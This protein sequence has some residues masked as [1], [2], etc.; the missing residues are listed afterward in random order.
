VALTKEVAVNYFRGKDQMRL[1]TDGDVAHPG[2]VI[3]D[4]NG[5]QIGISTNPLQINVGEVSDV[6]PQSFE[7]TS[8]VT[9]DSPADLDCNTELGR[10]A[11][12]GYIR[13][14]GAGDFTVKFSTDG[15]VFGDALTVKSDEVL[16]FSNISVDTI[17]I[18]WIA[19]SAYRVG[20]N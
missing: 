7:D 18:T 16:R 9:G 6:M 14:D 13:N 8:F 1:F 12:E 2:V 17:R 3:V 5:D 4:D 11:T 15:I 19:D 20:V 10:N